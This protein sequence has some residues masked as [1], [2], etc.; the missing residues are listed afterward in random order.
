MLTSRLTPRTNW[1]RLTHTGK[2]QLDATRTGGAAGSTHPFARGRGRVYRGPGQPG[3]SSSRSSCLGRRAC[4]RARR[5]LARTLR[6]RSYDAKEPKERDTSTGP[7]GRQR[8]RH[9]GA[10]GDGRHAI[11]RQTTAP[12]ESHPSDAA[13]RDWIPGREASAPSSVSGRAPPFARLIY[14]CRY[15]RPVDCL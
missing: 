13:A 7:A 4:A 11:G 10:P 2:E 3:R 14:S 9:R 1:S 12:E 6:N 15:H 5:A 8:S